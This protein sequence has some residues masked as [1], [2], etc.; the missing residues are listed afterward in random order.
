MEFTFDGG[1]TGHTH[2]RIL[3]PAGQTAPAATATAKPGDPLRP[4][5]NCATKMT[6]SVTKCPSC[7]FEY[8][9]KKG[10][11]GGGFVKFL[12]VLIILAAIGF[13][14]WKFVLHEKLPW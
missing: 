8:G 12:V 14:V 4:C 9:V 6:T 11:G 3:E 5:P 1:A 10:G 2:A 13:A 7:G